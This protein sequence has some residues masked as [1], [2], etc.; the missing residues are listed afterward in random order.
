[1]DHTMGKR[2]IYEPSQHQFFQRFALINLI[3]ILSVSVCPSGGS[4]L[5][6]SQRSDR[7]QNFSL[8][9]VILHDKSTQRLLPSLKS[10]D[11]KSNQFS[12]SYSSFSAPQPW[13]ATLAGDSNGKDNSLQT[14]R[15]EA[16]ANYKF[17]ANKKRIFGKDSNTSWIF[18]DKS[19]NWISSQFRHMHTLVKFSL[20]A[21]SNASGAVNQRDS[22]H[23]MSKSFV[24][25]IVQPEIMLAHKSVLYNSK[26]D[27]VSAS[28]NTTALIFFDRQRHKR[29]LNSIHA[30]FPRTVVH[31]PVNRTFSNLTKSENIVSASIL[32]RKL[33][34]TSMGG[35][36]PWGKRHE[37]G[38]VNKSISI[39]NRNKRVEGSN[40]SGIGQIANLTI[41]GLFELT[42]DSSALASGRSERIAAELAL[43]D[44]NAE[45]ILKGCRLVMHTNDTQASKTVDFC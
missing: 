41:L 10:T 34:G 28:R 13:T 3:L 39:T 33:D 43:E 22:S 14:K 32:W 44:I 38:F 25:Q 40:S 35:D 31:A 9:K 36:D 6:A 26:D 45:G 4:S 30:L 8:E 1:M 15:H 5:S 7:A 24:D 11:I 12:S 27:A 17:S 21:A 20:K 2:T 19:E 16:S 42:M 23:S 37:N 18:R 29:Q